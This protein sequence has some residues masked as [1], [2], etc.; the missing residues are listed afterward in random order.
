MRPVRPFPVSGYWFWL[1]VLREPARLHVYSVSF[2]SGAG[3]DTR[4]QVRHADRHVVAG[5]HPGGAADR[6]RALPGRGRERSAGVHHRAAGHAAAEAA[7]P[8]EARQELL[9]RERLSALLHDRDVRGRPADPGLGLV[10][11]GQG[12][13]PARLQKSQESAKRLWWSVVFEFSVR[14]PRVGP[15]APN[16]TKCCAEALVVSPPSAAAAPVL[17]QRGL[18]DAQ[19]LVQPHLG[20]DHGERGRRQGHRDRLVGRDERRQ[21]QHGRHQRPN[22]G[23]TSNSRLPRD[24]RADH[25]WKVYN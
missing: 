23:Q 15:G 16:D 8:V 1:V 20:D 14:M 10:A 7:R 18:V 5:L 13:R 22:D 17:G 19:P 24:S 3:G 2:L 21:R 9:L 4:R 11:A 25:H 6:L 12:A